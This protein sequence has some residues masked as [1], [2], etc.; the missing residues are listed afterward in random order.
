MRAAGR[1][2]IGEAHDFVLGGDIELAVDEGDTVRHGEA[3]GYGMLV[4]GEISKRLGRLAPLE[5]ESLKRAVRLCGRLPRTH[6]LNLARIEKA[7]AHDKKRTGGSIKWVLLERIGR[8]ALVDGREV[9]QKI[10]RDSLRAVLHEN[11]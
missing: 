3:V 8:A 5:L 9:P 6:D 11:S 10:L 1:I 4:A 7:L 2:K